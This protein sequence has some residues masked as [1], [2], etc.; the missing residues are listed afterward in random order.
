MSEMRKCKLCSKEY[1][2]N[3]FWSRWCSKECRFAAYGVRKSEKIKKE[4]L[5]FAGENLRKK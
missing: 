2:S 5:K 4:A 1:E 3:R